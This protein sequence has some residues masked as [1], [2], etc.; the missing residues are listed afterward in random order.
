MRPI[1]TG[2]EYMME[3][4]FDKLHIPYLVNQIFCFACNKYYKWSNRMNPDRCPYGEHPWTELGMF[5]RPDFLLLGDKNLGV[6]RVDGAIHDNKKHIVSDRFQ[7]RKFH[8]AGV[9]VFIVRNEH[10]DG[11]EVNKQRKRKSV[12][13][14]VVPDYIHMSIAYFF[15]AALNSDKI[16]DTYL[17]DKEVR[18]WL[19]LTSR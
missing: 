14:T 13:P 9:R 10:L 17:Q 1:R 15:W 16:Y 4:A 12:L 8:D 6:V 5:S 18:I 3:R 19:G 2:Q 7:V 11:F